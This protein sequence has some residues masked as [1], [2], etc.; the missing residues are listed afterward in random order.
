M[1]E[2]ICRML[3]YNIMNY[4]IWFIIF[5]DILDSDFNLPIDYEIYDTTK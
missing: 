5:N 3:Y 2:K 1:Y 4:F